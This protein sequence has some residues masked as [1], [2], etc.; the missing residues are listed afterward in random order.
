[1][2]NAKALFEAQISEVGTVSLDEEAETRALDATRALAAQLFGAQE[3]NI[4]ILTSATEGLCQLAWAIR[5]PA[6][7]NVVSIDL[8]FPSVVYPWMRVAQ[9]TGAEIRLVR[10]LQSPAQLSFDDVAST[11]DDRTAVLCVSHVQYATGHR[12]DLKAVA[13]LA[14]GHGAL[15]VVDATQSAGIIPIDVGQAPVDALVAA[16]YK[17]LCG[18]FGAALLYVA[19]DLRDRLTPPIVG[20]RSVVQQFNFDATTVAFFKQARKFES[21]TMNYPSGFGLGEAIKYVLPI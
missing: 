9:E 10:A 6:G 16:G 15:C 5:P 4:A 14:H 21:G 17:W 13:D 2:R 19:P 3:E 18:P 8:E 20:W 1:V 7:S 11:I 12:F